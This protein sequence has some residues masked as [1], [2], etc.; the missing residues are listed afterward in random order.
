MPGPTVSSG[1]T[2][3]IAAGITSGL[4][5]VLS[6]GTLDVLNGGT[7]EFTAVSGTEIVLGT[8]T[9]GG[10]A[11]GGLQIVSSGG[12]ISADMVSSGGTQT[13]LGGVVLGGVVG[14][15]GIET[16]SSGGLASGV[17]AEGT[18]IVVAGG[19]A[20]GT[21]VYTNEEVGGGFVMG[22]QVREGLMYVQGTATASGSAFNTTLT[23]DSLLYVVSGGVTSGTILSGL[24][25]QEIISASG[26]AFGTIVSSGYQIVEGGFT[27]GTVLVSGG[28][29]DIYTGGV[30][31]ND[32]VTSGGTVE[33]Y[34]ALAFTEALGSSTTFSGTLTGSGT[35]VQSG[36]GTLKLAGTVSGFIGAYLISGGTLELTSP[37]N[38]AS[39][40]VQFASGSTATLQIDGATAPSA[41]ISNL[42]TGDVIDLAGLSFVSSG[43]ISVNGNTV[44]VTEGGMSESLTIYGASFYP[45]F[46]G[47]P[48]PGSGTDLT[49]ACYCPGT[50]ILSD[51]GEMPVEAL[52]IGDVVVTVSGEHRPIKWIG[53]RSYAGRF[54][55]ANPMVQ[56]VRL[57]T[58][59][60]GNGLPRRDLLVSPEHGMFLGGVLIPARCLVNG[61][62]IAQERGLERIDYFHVELDSHDVLLAEGAPSE[63]FMDDDSRGVF[64]NAHEFATLYPD[65]SDPGRFCAPKVDDGYQLEA[66]RRRLAV[67]AGGL[68][69]AA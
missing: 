25:D 41:V 16:V 32:V 27:S 39:S 1:S 42:N 2:L 54:L 26:S 35:L 8:E 10:V 55:A 7:A 45:G 43:G 62:T 44:T 22:T 37:G 47:S 17:T 48:N 66:I 64:H 51:R 63:S 12:V 19:S 61:S 53:N 52:R 21:I 38:L 15:G 20:E 18:Q 11:S 24:F 34:A 9:S 67:V 29:Q 46:I 31:L 5:T 23:G 69:E 13:V 57:R 6:G 3:V 28:T 4:V 56:P 40:T 58:G 33:D 14:L 59:C 49:V 65:A 30:A 50:L 68:V 36:P 60:L